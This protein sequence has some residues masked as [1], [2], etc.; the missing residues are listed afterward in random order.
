MSQDKQSAMDAACWEGVKASFRLRYGEEVDDARLEDLK[1]ANRIGGAWECERV[2]ARAAI[3]AY[4]GA[5]VDE[6]GAVQACARAINV[7][8]GNNS[9]WTFWEDEARAVLRTL[10]ERAKERQG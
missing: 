7:S 1:D 5:L 9:H 4:L 3:L 10:I 6:E 8:A 2:A